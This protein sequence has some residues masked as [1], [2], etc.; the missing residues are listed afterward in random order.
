M[1][2][3]QKQRRKGQNILQIIYI[4]EKIATSLFCPNEAKKFNL[5]KIGP[6]VLKSDEKMCD[7]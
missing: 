1:R 5:K 6:R 2:I 4:C 7:V 3:S